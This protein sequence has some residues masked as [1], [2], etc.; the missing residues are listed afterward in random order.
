MT[1]LGVRFEQTMKLGEQPLFVNNA[2][3]PPWPLSKL[4]MI[5]HPWIRQTLT[6]VSHDVVYVFMNREYEHMS[7][8][9]IVYATM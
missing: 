4:N 1:R 7:V 2:L 3:N 5:T 8:F 9:V 6:S